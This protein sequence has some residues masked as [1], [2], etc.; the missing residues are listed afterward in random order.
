MA[1]VTVRTRAAAA[2]TR[3]GV[4]DSK[5]F[6]AGDEAHA[7]RSELAARL[8]DLADHIEI[9][10]IHVEEIDRRVLVGQLNW[11]EREHAVSII[12]A[13][14]PARRIICDGERMFAPLCE[15]YPHLEARDKGETHHVAVAAAS[16]VAKVERDEHFR[17]IARRYEPEFGPITGGGYENA[18]TRRF[19]ER[20]VAVY[21]RLPP[22]A[23]TSWGGSTAQLQLKMF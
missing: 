23:R 3:A 2:L 7:R 6:G 21:G 20:Y 5:A 13:S 14:P 12:D 16:I 10:V 11:L 19:L 18:G 17:A 9:R 22:E 15:R 4:T 8:R 1:G